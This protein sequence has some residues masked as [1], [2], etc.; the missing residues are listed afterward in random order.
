MTPTDGRSSPWPRLTGISLALSRPP[1]PM[2]AM[3]SN[4]LPSPISTL[5][6]RSKPAT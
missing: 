4:E 3:F 5:I 2:P 1:I 6:Q